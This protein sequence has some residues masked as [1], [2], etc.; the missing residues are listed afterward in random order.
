MRVRWGGHVGFV[1]DFRNKKQIVARETE[2]NIP[3]G[4]H[5]YKWESII[6]VNL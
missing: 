3:L 6:N 1:G 2:L 5:R 4:H